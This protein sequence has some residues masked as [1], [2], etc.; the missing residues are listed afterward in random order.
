MA[1]QSQVP[2]WTIENQNKP[3]EYTTAFV[4]DNLTY[5]NVT[6]VATGQRWIYTDRGLAGRFLVS[7]T[8]PNGDVTTGP[9]YA[10]ENI[11]GGYDKLNT[12]S[13]NL[14]EYIIAQAATPQQIINVGKTSEYKSTFG[15][16][17][18]AGI[19]TT[20]VLS[21]G[22]EAPYVPDT[23]NPIVSIGSI[24]TYPSNM[25]SRQDRIVFTAVEIKPREEQ[26]IANGAGVDSISEESLSAFAIKDPEYIQIAGSVVLPIQ[27]GIQ[28]QNSA[29]W[30]SDSISSIDAFLYNSASALI[31]TNGKQESTS[32]VIGGMGGNIKQA[33]TSNIGR[34]QRYF[35]GQAA[36]IQGDIVSRTQGVVLNPNME[37]I[38]QAPQLRPFSFTFKLTARSS[39]EAKKI[40]Q[41]IKY[42]KRHMA[43]RVENGL[44]LKAPHVFTIMYQQ[45]NNIHPGIGKISPSITKR[46]CALQNFTVDYT[47]LGS[48]MTYE[49]GTMVSYTIGLQFSEIQPIYD[50]NYDD[51]KEGYS[52]PIGY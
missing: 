14:S 8:S 6:D 27:T 52:H 32:D 3:T 44:F 38:F 49:D 28:D 10:L 19:A 12:A 31:G 7:S 41:I 45:G 2:N 29:S 50:I 40:K 17:R 36:G 30:N 24:V 42:F 18:S 37:L 25:D 35:A 13:K 16:S 22:G 46:A 11:F 43:V 39:D 21:P 1:A 26:S 48:Y 9:E 4:V 20:S 23:R 51:E 5:V 47:P 15:A 33:M 34:L